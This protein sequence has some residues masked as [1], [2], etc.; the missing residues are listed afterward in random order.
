M[1]NL[2]LGLINRACQFTQVR[3][4]TIFGGSGRN[5]FGCMWYAGGGRGRCGSKAVHAVQPGAAAVPGPVAGARHARHGRRAHRVGIPARAGAAHGRSG[6]R[7]CGR[8]QPPHAAAGRG[9]VD[10]LPPAQPAQRRL[11]TWNTQADAACTCTF[12]LQEDMCG[13]TRNT[14]SALAAGL[15]RLCSHMCTYACRLSRLGSAATR[16]VRCKP[17]CQLSIG[18]RTGTK[19]Y[20]A[21]GSQVDR[22]CGR[23]DAN[24]LPGQRLIMIW[25]MV[26]D[27]AWE[28]REHVLQVHL[29][30]R[31]L[32]GPALMQ[33]VHQSLPEW[34]CRCCQEVCAWMP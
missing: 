12:Q 27:A 11:L 16:H 18:C 32:D 10:A 24:A 3:V 4:T 7:R 33:L 1:L 9:H 25:H 21:C 5:K 19:A 22:F 14:C 30:C 29:A 17:P 2:T 31:L 23:R 26:A 8:D 34:T 15:A 13:T 28:E 6:R 20:M